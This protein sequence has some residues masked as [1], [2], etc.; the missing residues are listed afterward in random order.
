M[1]KKLKGKISD[2]KAEKTAKDRLKVW[3]IGYAKVE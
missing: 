3:G 1:S 2:K